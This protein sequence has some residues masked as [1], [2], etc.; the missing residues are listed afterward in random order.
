MDKLDFE[1]LVIPERTCAVFET[2]RRKRPIADY[3]AIRNCIATEWLPASRYELT[4]E[5]EVIAMH[6]RAKD[7]ERERYIEICLPV[8]I[9]E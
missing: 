1:T 4:D 2:E 8:R 3:I 6:W 7:A 5:P 9:N